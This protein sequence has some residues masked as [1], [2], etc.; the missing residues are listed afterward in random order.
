MSYHV[1]W[2]PELVPEAILVSLII[3]I[4]S[5]VTAG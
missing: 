2:L 1:E 5:A 3:C 4:F